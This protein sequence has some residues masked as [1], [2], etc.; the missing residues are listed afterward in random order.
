LSVSSD[1][2]Y[3]NAFIMSTIAQSN[4]TGLHLH[5]PASVTETANPIVFFAYDAVSVNY[6]LPIN[7]TIA[8][9]ISSGNAYVNVHS[10]TDQGGELRG[11][12]EPLGVALPLTSSTSTSF[13][14]TTT[15]TTTTSGTSSKSTTTNASS[16]S[17]VTTGSASSITASLFLTVAAVLFLFA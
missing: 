5:G 10:D 12:V 17:F 3:L 15:T 1:D 4:V 2:S 16:G 13:S 11:Q 7:S 6:Y 8:G 9:W 14:A